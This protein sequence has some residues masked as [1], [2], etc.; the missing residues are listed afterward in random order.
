MKIFGI[1]GWQNSGKTT[2]GCSLIKYFKN[3]N[4]SVSAIKQTHHDF[5]IDK[6]DKD[7][8]LLRKSGTNE[9]LITSPNRWAIIHE[10]C[11]NDIPNI[12]DLIKNIQPVDILLI[13]GNKTDAYP[14]ISVHRKNNK[15]APLIKEAENIVAFATDTKIKTNKPQFELNNIAEIAK[16]ILNY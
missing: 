14:K 2:L 3:N 9:I 5:E 8:F 4:L 1:V 10:N 13:E 16:F 6:K 15:K 11:N 12:N 7:S